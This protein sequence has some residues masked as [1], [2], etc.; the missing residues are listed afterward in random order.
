MIFRT[1]FFICK[2]CESISRHSNAKKDDHKWWH[3]LLVL[4]K[5][6]LKP[7]I[8]IASNKVDSETTGT[9]VETQ[10][11]PADSDVEDISR[12]SVAFFAQ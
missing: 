12:I 7:V 2:R 9:R 8:E 10:S 6:L 1:D 5:G 11:A 4:L 3:S